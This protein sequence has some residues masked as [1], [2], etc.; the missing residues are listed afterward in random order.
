[1][2]TIVHPSANMGL[3]LDRTPFHDEYMIKYSYRDNHGETI[4]L[5]C[6]ATMMDSKKVGLARYAVI[7]PHLYNV[8]FVNK[9]MCT[10]GITVRDGLV[11]KPGEEIFRQF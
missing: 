4:R 1:M 7:H 10:W 2:K 6:D 5:K 11:I 9:G 8:K 3:T